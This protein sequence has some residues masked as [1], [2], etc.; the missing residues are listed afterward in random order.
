[1]PILDRLRPQPRWKH[2]DPAVRLV[3]VH[4]LAYDDQEVLTS[5]ARG[6]DD[7]RVRR[8]AVQ[9]LHDPIV[10]AELAQADQ[11]EQVREVVRLILVE[12]ATA[13]PDAD[14]CAVAMAGLH[15]PRDL[16]AIAKTAEHEPVRRG[17][18]ARLEDPRL[19]GN[20]ARLAADAGIRLDALAR[21]SE[22]VELCH[23]AVKSEYKDVAV[24][25]VERLAEDAERLAT[26]ATR[27]KTKAAGRRARTALGALRPDTESPDVSGRR[28]ELCEVMEGLTRSEDWGQLPA[29]MIEIEARW[30]DLGQPGDVALAER[31]TTAHEAVVQRLSHREDSLAEEQRRVAEEQTRVLGPRIR[32]CETVESIADHMREGARR[33][34]TADADADRSAM[35]AGI[36]EPDG[37]LAR[38][39]EIRTVWAALAPVAD[40]QGDALTRRFDE[41]CRLVERR[42]TRWVAARAVRERREAICQ[43]AERLAERG[44]LQ[45]ALRDWEELRRRWNRPDEPMESIEPVEPPAYADLTARL[46][47]VG[48]DLKARRARA[49]E[50]RAKEAHENLARLRGLCDEL[51]E[52]GRADDLTLRR[53]DQGARRAREALEDLGRLPSPRN[54]EEVGRRLRGARATLGGRIRE[55]RDAEEWS[56]WAKVGVQEE[57]CRRMEALIDLPDTEAVAKQL[58][59][60]QDQWAQVQSVPPGRAESLFRRFRLAQHQ[61][62]V[63][64]DAYFAQSAAERE[65]NL[66]RKR[67]LCEQ[68][69]ALARSSRWARTAEEFKRLQADWKQIGPVPR[70]EAKAVW[71]RFRAACD[72]FFSR[73]AE[74]LQT[75]KAAWAENL[76]RK[77][78][79]C[80]RAEGLRESTDW[81]ATAAALKRLQAEWKTVGPV[82][83]Q[84]SEAIWRRFRAACDGFFERYQQRDQ[85]ESAAK[86][87]ER[88][89]LCRALEEL[90]PA[91]GAASDA[92]PVPDG[93]AEQVRDLRARWQRAAVVRDTQL[94][95]LA[96][97]FGSALERLVAR[98]PDA[99]RGT[100]LDPELNRQRL[101]R[102]CEIV[103]RQ[104]GDVRPP[105]TDDESPAI[106]LARR[107]RDAMA[108]NTI[109][110]R[111]DESARWLTADEA[112]RKA[113]ADWERVGRVP[114]DT[115]SSLEARFEAA[116]AEVAAAR[117]PSAPGPR[118]GH[119][120]SPAK[121]REG[122]R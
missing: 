53:A 19:V 6:D 107:W 105:V 95:P 97:R 114:L 102:L 33:E 60:I 62:R 49:R 64:C 16:A 31:F 52:L 109:G 80:V 11:D 93:I 119:A 40:P 5:I 18:L 59:E 39:D 15:E 22:P 54:Q 113:R 74:E 122:E 55:L 88:D 91:D 121:K 77:E 112:V 47:R 118:R 51:E 4:E 38:L 12:Q 103:E 43:E 108:S 100:D 9:K 120:G 26:V 85:V 82:R 83:H 70:K 73:R 99:F 86:L 1:M 27:A 21:I 24:A 3:A 13:G 90:V 104:A 61:V 94:A 67:Q 110:G 41:A 34:G 32:L 14:A 76:A 36:P 17:A 96:E 7:A 92:D 29:R 66:A 98:Y 63:R 25:A 35:P 45:A 75:R 42:H 111:V 106:V 8:I 28:L 65:D 56:Q 48:A 87:A 72:T 58:R 20:V 84:K 44:D 57:L 117:P 79:L 89:A 116:C 46:D 23:V 37:V 78:Q 68:A 115:R 71:K 50:A 2:A 101:E 30:R 69:E 10:L 81:T